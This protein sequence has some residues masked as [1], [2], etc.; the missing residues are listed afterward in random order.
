MKYHNFYID[1]IRKNLVPK[2]FCDYGKFM[3]PDGGYSDYSGQYKALENNVLNLPFENC[4]FE[5]VSG[6]G[7]KIC[8]HVKYQQNVFQETGDTVNTIGI[9]TFFNNPI[10][11]EWKMY[12]CLYVIRDPWCIGVQKKNYMV[13]VKWDKREWRDD[14]VGDKVEL[15]SSIVS[16]ILDALNVLAC[17]NVTLERLPKKRHPV[18]SAL[19]MDDYWILKVEAKGHISEDKG[20]THRSPRE[21]VRR[22]HPHTYHTKNG[23]IVHWI[24]AIKVN[25]GKGGMISKEYAIEKPKS[26][27]IVDNESQLEH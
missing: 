12:P 18:A 1:L 15:K 27:W 2:D 8:T 4:L 5:W 23:T 10:N 21:H 26:N 19:P 11:N 13:N 6:G 20:G 9:Q 3:L 14:I 24:N 16:P 22:G 7:L 25:V 17:S